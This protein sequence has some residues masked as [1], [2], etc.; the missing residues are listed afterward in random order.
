MKL[1]FVL[2]VWIA[3]FLN[4]LKSSFILFVLS[5]FLGCVCFSFGLRACSRICICAI[6][7]A[8]FLIAQAFFQSL[9]P[10]QYSYLSQS[11][12]HTCI[13]FEL[14]LFFL[15]AFN[16]VPTS[17]SSRSC[18]ILNVKL[19]DTA[20]P[21]LLLTAVCRYCCKQY[22]WLLQSIPIKPSHCE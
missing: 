16:R 2:F 21:S 3:G 1:F 22:L 12:M 18:S 6:Y 13:C 14:T 20:T 15:F 19:V 11:C 10:L 5:I 7:S 4:M 17:L 9:V 8:L